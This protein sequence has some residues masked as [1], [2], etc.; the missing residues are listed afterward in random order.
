MKRLIRAGEPIIKPIL[1]VA[2]FTG[3]RL[4]EIL[5]LRWSKVDFDKEQ[6]HVVSSWRRGQGFTP[7]KS[8]SSVR[9]VPICAELKRSLLAHYKKMGRPPDDELVFFPDVLGDRHNPLRRDFERALEKS[10]VTKVRFHD[11]RHTAASLFIEAGVDTLT[12]QKIMGHSSAAITLDLYGHLYSSSFDR[13]RNGMDR[14]M[15]GSDNVIRLPL[16]NDE[17]AAQADE[18][19]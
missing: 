8:K 15:S 16:R 2:C 11:L 18:G 13:A 14:L 4:G 3:M 17:G 7:P 10:R 12:L 1:M 5:A 6:I 9:F 19:S